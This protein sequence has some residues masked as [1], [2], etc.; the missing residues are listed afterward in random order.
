MKPTENDEGR[1]KI[2][3]L[4]LGAGGADAFV[5]ENRAELSTAVL[6][7]VRLAV[8]QGLDEVEVFEVEELGA[9]FS[10]SRKEM[11]GSLEGCLDYFQSV[12]E[13][14][15]CNEIINLKTKI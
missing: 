10:L 15:K 11:S 12:E 8:E 9:V 7:A 6:A 4:R 13:Y 3:S 1:H 14:E 5:Q 2:P